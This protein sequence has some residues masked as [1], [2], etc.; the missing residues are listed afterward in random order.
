MFALVEYKS[1]VTIES[2]WLS[3][4]HKGNN[5]HV[6]INS[7]KECISNNFTSRFVCGRIHFQKSYIFFWF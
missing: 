2:P 1:A 6:M 7:V 5:I 3:K 4:C